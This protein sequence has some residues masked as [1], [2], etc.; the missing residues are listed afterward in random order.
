MRVKAIG[1][2]KNSD[3][4][5]IGAKFIELNTGKAI[6]DNTS[7]ILKVRDRVEC[8]NAKIDRNGFVKAKFGHKLNIFYTLDSNKYISNN[9]MYKIPTDIDKR[10]HYI[11]VGD[12]YTN[13]IVN[14]LRLECMKKSR[15]INNNAEVMVAI[16]VKTLEYAF[17]IGDYSS[18]SFKGNIDFERIV[19]ESEQHSVIL[20]HNHPSNA[21]FSL[22][23]IK[24]FNKLGSVYA[25]EAIG[26]LGDTYMLIKRRIPAYRELQNIIDK[27]EATGKGD[28]Q[29]LDS[30]WTSSIYTGVEYHKHLAKY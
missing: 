8:V 30:V 25:I 27:L 1:I 5:T 2:I 28:H 16:N 29:S 20:T 21:S 13:K 24:S 4:I 18:I 11:K 9:T 12:N 7:N 15:D 23:D 17:E 6:I 22:K 19:Y 26:N 10:L 3:N 14:N